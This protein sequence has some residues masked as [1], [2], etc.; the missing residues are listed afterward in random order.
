MEKKKEEKP[1]LL[2]K[3]IRVLSLTPL[4]LW[5]PLFVFGIFLFDNP[6]NGSGFTFLFFLVMIAYPLVII[7]NVILSNTVYKK[8]S[9]IAFSL[10]LWPPI[11]V[12][13][14]VWDFLN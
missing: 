12:G 3:I 5:P 2:F 6:D 10:L 7:G 8:S 14:F 11:V 4:L 13:L 9:I 1:G